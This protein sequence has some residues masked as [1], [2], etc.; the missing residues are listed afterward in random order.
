MRRLVDPALWAMVMSFAATVTAGA[1]EPSGDE[2]VLPSGAK[3]EELWNDGEFTEGAA[4]GPDG[5]IYFSDIPSTVDQPGRVLKFD[6]KTRKTTV[7]CPDSRKSNGLMFDRAGRLIACCG[8]NGGARAL[9]EITP[10][11]KVKPIVGEFEGKTFNAP[12]DLVILPNGHIYFSDPR[13]VGPEPVELDHMSVYL[14]KPDDGSVTRVTDDIEK[15]NGVHVSP[16]ARTLYVAETNNGSG[17]VTSDTAETRPGR[18]TLNAFRI[19]RNGELGRKRVL[20]DFGAGPG[21][22]G[23]TLDAEGNLYAA[24]RKTG[25]HGIIVYRPD[26]AERAYI[27]TQDLPTNC[28]FGRGEDAKTLYVTA[29]TGLYCIR[30]NIEGYHPSTS[31]Q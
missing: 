16:D 21:V 13:Y 17:D 5:A 31:Q 6:P 8:A 14:Y 27:P 4:V 19:R 11:G 1:P 30:L 15:P 12:N 9:C 3:L 20:V 10:D 28:C 7:H 25:R 23:M 29:G 18:M 26:G 24:V 22:D 2:A